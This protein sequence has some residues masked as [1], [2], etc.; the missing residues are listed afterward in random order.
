MVWWNR[1]RKQTLNTE[2]WFLGWV[3][4]MY[5]LSPLLSL[6]LSL[7]LMIKIIGPHLDNN[8]I[9]PQYTHKYIVSSTQTPSPLSLRLFFPYQLG[10]EMISCLPILWCIHRLKLYTLLAQSSSSQI[11]FFLLSIES[12]WDLDGSDSPSLGFFGHTHV[13]VLWVQ[14]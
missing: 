3:H 1:I 7:S 13:E 12:S 11:N 14:R 5:L 2:S 9:S 6:S 4:C 10:F 8:K